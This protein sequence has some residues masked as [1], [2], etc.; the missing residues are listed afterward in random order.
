M[1]QIYSGSKTL[2]IKTTERNQLQ[3]LIKIL[4]KEYH[5]VQDHYFLFIDYILGNK[6]IDVMLFKKN[7]IILLDLKGYSGIIHGYEDGQWYVETDQ[8]DVV[9]DQDNNPFVQIR[10]QRYDVMKFLR[11]KLPSIDTR[12]S[13][14]IRNIAGWLYFNENTSFDI[15]QINVK[16]RLWFKVVTPSNLLEEVKNEDSNE[17]IFR[18]QELDNLAQF[19]GGVEF[20]IKKI[21]IHEKEKQSAPKILPV[22]DK[23]DL[24]NIEELEKKY[25]IVPGFL[26]EI[27]TLEEEHVYQ[28]KRYS[29]LKDFEELIAHYAGD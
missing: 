7:A 4:Y 21:G 1:L 26:K 20:D 13:E 25:N 16:N 3:G 27:I 11:E 22:E 2:N 15:G 24:P 29:V 14:G 17:F 23:F 18:D 12:F 5:H 19:F 9:I 6:Q 28:P 10:N 8:G